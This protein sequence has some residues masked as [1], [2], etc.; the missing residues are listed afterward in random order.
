[1]FSYLKS[2]LKVLQV[3][4]VDHS[5]LLQGHMPRQL[6]GRNP[7]ICICNSFL[8]SWLDPSE[9]TVP[10]PA[11]KIYALLPIFCE[12]P[13]RIQRVSTFSIYLT[14]LLEPLTMSISHLRDYKT[15]QTVQI[16][17]P[18]LHFKVKRFEFL[19]R[20]LSSFDLQ[21]SFSDASLGQWA[22]FLQSNF[23]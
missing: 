18:N 1:M 21:T 10:I 15:I 8:S 7:H 12:L 4:F 5:L 6:S 9:E 22:E 2:Q 23:H 16:W 19:T 11:W 20:Y 13:R 14:P 3:G 17:I